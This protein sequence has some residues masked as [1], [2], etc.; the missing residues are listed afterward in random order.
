VGPAI[1]QAAQEARAQ[2]LEIAAEE[3]EADPADLEIVDGAVQVRGVP[4]KTISL[5]EIAAKAM[6]FG[7]KYAPVMGRGRH[8]DNTAS[9][10]FCAQLVEVEVDGETGEVRPC[11]VVMVQDVGRAINPLGVQGQMRGGAVQ[12]LGWALYER[13]VYDD[14]GQLLTGSW[15]E[16]AV[17]HAV[18]AA[19]EI[20]TVIVEVPSDRGPFGARGVGEPPVIATAAAVANAIADVTGRRPT[21]LPMTPPRVRDQLSRA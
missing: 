6:E 7:G 17:P 21:D 9:P 3:F 12:G 13:M 11:R 18:Q 19:P 10:G 1:I 4:D 8:A 2:V 20:E 16:Y 5:G 14:G 15:M